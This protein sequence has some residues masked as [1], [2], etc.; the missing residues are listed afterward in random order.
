MTTMK[1]RD[2]AASLQ[3]LD[4]ASDKTGADAVC[5]AEVNINPATGLANDYLNHFNEAIMML[6]MLSSCPEFRDDFL[7]WQPMSYREHFASS[8]FKGRD[9]AIAAYENADAK[10]RE[11]LDALADAMTAELQAARAV[12]RAEAAPEATR[13]AAE[14]AVRTLKPLVARAGAVI[15]GRPPADDEPA[16]Q[17]AVDSLMQG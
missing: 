14:N 5:F 13:L 10:T 16:P 8:S 1:Y 12:L 2:G 3:A 15:N 7:S 6:E 4:Q 17:A 11:R 9:M